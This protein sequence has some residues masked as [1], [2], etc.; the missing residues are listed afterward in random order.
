MSA[1]E[2]P[3]ICNSCARYRGNGQCDA[4]PEAIPD[5]IMWGTGD[6]RDPRSGDRGLLYVMARRDDAQFLFDAWLAYFRASQGT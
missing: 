1:D 2:M 6:H 5:D 4:F 3:K